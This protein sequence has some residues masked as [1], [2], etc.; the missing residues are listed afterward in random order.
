MIDLSKIKN[1]EIEGIQTWD[2]PDFVD[3]FVSYAEFE[4]GQPLTDLQ[5]EWVNENAPEFVNEQVYLQLF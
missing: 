4:N 2:S 3:A 1:V 5:L